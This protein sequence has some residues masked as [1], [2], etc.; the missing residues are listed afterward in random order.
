MLI[1]QSPD[2]SETEDE[3]T[4]PPEKFHWRDDSGRGRM[5]VVSSEGEESD[6]EEEAGNETVNTT[7][8]EGTFVQDRV[9][10]SSWC[11][12][13]IVLQKIFAGAKFLSYLLTLQKKI[14]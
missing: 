2:N 5:G 14:S 11:C 7:L 6:D 12:T 13:S 10:I 4:S 9:M 8:T 1:L 3:Q